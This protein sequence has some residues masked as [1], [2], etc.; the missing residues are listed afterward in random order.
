[1]VI[2]GVEQARAHW[3]QKVST[4]DN[5]HFAVA[6][7][8]LDPSRLDPVMYGRHVSVV[9]Y[10]GTRYYVFEGQS[11]RDRFLNPQHRRVYSARPCSDPCGA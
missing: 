4:F 2:K 9:F 11:N 1:M 10:L 6:S 5:P 8:E 3:K 7:T